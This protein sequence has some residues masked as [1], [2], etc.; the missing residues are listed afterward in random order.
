M[1]KIL[2][3]SD[4]VGIGGGE[5]SLINI[6]EELNHR[7][8]EITV[9]TP[10]R[11]KLVDILENKNVNVQINNRL[12]AKKKTFFLLPMVLILIFIFLHRGKYD[13]VHSNSHGQ[14]YPFGLMSLILGKKFIYTCHGQWITFSTWQQIYFNTVCHQIIAVSKNV[15]SNLL[16]YSIDNKKIVQIYLGIKIE[17]YKVNNKKIRHELGLDANHKLVGMI[18]RFQEIKGHDIYIKG[19][20]ELLMRGDHSNTTFLIIGGETFNNSSDKKFMDDVVDE[21]TNS[22]LYTKVK[23]LGERQDI[24][25]IL[26]EM[27]LL[28][29]PSRNES[30]GMVI[31][32]AMAARCSVIASNCDGPREIIEDETTGMLFD[33]GSYKQLAEKMHLMLKDSQLSQRMVDSA[34]S[35]VQE[36][37]SIEKVVDK[38]ELIYR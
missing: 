3:I 12:F 34:Y 35:M 2:F 16:R 30:F 33:N 15:Q 37:F 10:T 21:V 1:K 5:T 8:Y 9:V 14:C 17:N 13:I 31:I 22:S 28:V 19:I 11:G 24:P 20:K 18:A 7:D 6:I 38:Y 4:L 36:N 27:D 23:L 32:E 26:S 25:D 29:V